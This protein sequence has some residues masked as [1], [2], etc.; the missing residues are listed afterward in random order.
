[1][2]FRNN[3]LKTGLLTFLCWRARLF[4]ELHITILYQFSL[5]SLHDVVLWQIDPVRLISFHYVI[6][7]SHETVTRNACRN[8]NPLN[9]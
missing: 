5:P 6:L 4:F 3:R 1:M 2:I 8:R 7:A 9:G